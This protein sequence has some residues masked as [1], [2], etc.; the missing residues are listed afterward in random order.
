M[1]ANVNNEETEQTRK[2]A[3]NHAHAKTTLH[4]PSIYEFLYLNLFTNQ[5]PKLVVCLSVGHILPSSDITLHTGHTSKRS[6]LNVIVGGQTSTH[7][8]VISSATDIDLHRGH[9]IDAGIPM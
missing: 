2:N 6:V 3:Y 4:Y 7:I 5:I 8:R 9:S 1:K